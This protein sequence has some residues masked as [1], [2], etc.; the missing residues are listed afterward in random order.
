MR[1]AGLFGLIG[2]VFL[3][4]SMTLSLSRPIFSDTLPVLPPH[5]PG[6][7]IIRWREGTSIKGREATSD[8]DVLR[9]LNARRMDAIPALRIE[10]W[11]VP[12]GRLQQALEVVR[13]DSRVAWAEPNGLLFLP[14]TSLSPVSFRSQKQRTSTAPK[15]VAGLFVPNDP[16]YETYADR[17]LRPLGVESAWAMTR[18]DPRLVVAVIDTGVDC[19]H[20]D[21]VGACWVNTGEIPGNGV[22]DDHNGYVDDVGGWNFTTDTPDVRDV[23]YHG[24]HVAGIIAAR[25]NNGKGIA[26]IAGNVTI[27][28]LAIFQPQGVGTYYDLIRALLYATD[29]GARV[30]NLSLGA[31]SYSLG[32]AAAVRYAVKHGVVVVAAAGNMGMRRRFYPAAHPEVIAVSAL[33]ERGYPASFTNYGDYIDVAAPGVSVISTIPHNGYGAASG[34]SMA[35]PHVSGLAALLLSRHPTL[36]PADVRAYIRQTARDR[37][38]PPD[39][40][41]PGR[42]PYYGYGRIHIGDAVAAVSPQKISPVR[43]PLPPTLPWRPTCE[44]LV[45][46]GGFEEGTNRWHLSG[47]QVV[48]SPVFEGHKALQFDADRSGVAWQTLPSLPRPLRM[49]VYMAIRIETSDAGAGSKYTFP[50]DDWLEVSL[51]QEDK[52]QSILLLR[53]GNSSDNVSNGLAWD[54]VLGVLPAGLLPDMS[55]APWRLVFRSG[56]DGDTFP[57]RFT[58]DAVRLCAVQARYHRIFSY[59]P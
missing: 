4:V 33:D 15:R 9:D 34:T 59:F 10:R 20:E 36:S 22:D 28:P 2:L 53:M 44:D 54:Q 29:N 37:V 23:H 57:T 6:E 3:A 47:A 14:E 46:N 11:R 19:Q 43:P 31:T 35:A 21:L 32:E 7:L 50:Y 56:N 30:I 12:P 48:D 17:Y 24:T 49:T 16:Y 45:V 42:D 8:E 38:G 40:D 55:A 13:R 26:G 58:V 18:G 51:E 41:T 27:M 5:V 1:R 52:R 25:I 39:K